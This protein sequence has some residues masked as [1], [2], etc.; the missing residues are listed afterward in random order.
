M[1]GEKHVAPIELPFPGAECYNVA[2]SAFSAEDFKTSKKIVARLQAT[3]FIRSVGQGALIV[4]FTLYLSDLG[5]NAASIG[6]LFSASGLL[7]AVL[8]WFVG[9][10]SDRT[11]RKPFVLA[12]E[13]LAIVAGVLLFFTDHAVALAAACLLLGFGHSQSGVPSFAA[14]AEQAWLAEGVPP[15]RRGSVFSMN[16]A[17]G[18]FGMATGSALAGAVPLLRLFV[19]ELVAYR[20]YFLLAALFAFIN[21]LLLRKV[22]ER[23]EASIESMGERKGGNNSVSSV[24]SA[25][26]E[27]AK[28]DPVG[29]RKEENG[30]MLK[31]ALIN[32]LNGVAVGLTSPLLVYW[33]NLKFGVGPGELGPVYAITFVVTGLASVWTG[34]LS[35]RMGIVKAVVTVRLSAVVLLIATPLMPTFWL[36][37]VAH[38]LRSALARGSVGARRALA[39]NLVRSERR[40]IASSVNNVSMAMPMAIG[41]TIAGYFLEVGQ[42]AMPFFIGAALQFL[43]GTLYGAAFNRYDAAPSHTPPSN[44]G[45]GQSNIAT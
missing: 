3:R 20:P 24:A 9:L 45:Q 37:S 18:F 7:G 8:G 2:M 30:I 17:L 43:Y 22:A 12:Y 23:L 25:F 31:M 6:I 40:G 19:P 5:W 13:T 15:S 14:A 44:Q 10:A 39:V 42:L 21:Y 41:P 1:K 34:K 35:D 36:A 29:V 27:K 26:A 16:S 11:K 28:V 32:G 38:V 33:F 4:L